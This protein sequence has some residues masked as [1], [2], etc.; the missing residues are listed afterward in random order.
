[1]CDIEC[2]N[3]VAK[4]LKVKPGKITYNADKV[5][6]VFSTF[7]LYAKSYCEITFSRF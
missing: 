1:M 2:V 7:I 3:K 6:F 4:F 5:I